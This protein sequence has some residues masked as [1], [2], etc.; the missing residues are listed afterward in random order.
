MVYKV[1]IHIYRYRWWLFL[2]LNIIEIRIG[3][4]NCKA[5]EQPFLILTYALVSCKLPRRERHNSNSREVLDF[6]VTLT[7]NFGK[8]KRTKQYLVLWSEKTENK[9]LHCVQAA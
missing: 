2:L 3:A 4:L 9:T 6:C 5:Q 7:V 8:P 1:S